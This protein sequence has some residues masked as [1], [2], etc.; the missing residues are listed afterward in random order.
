M[1]P[2]VKSHIPQTSQVQGWAALMRGRLF[3]AASKISQRNHT[4]DMVKLKQAT[5]FLLKIDS[6]YHH[7]HQLTSTNI[8]A[9]NIN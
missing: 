1:N 6:E 5:C 4:S 8:K 2:T 9:A 7:L 3:D